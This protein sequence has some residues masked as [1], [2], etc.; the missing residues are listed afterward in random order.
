VSAEKTIESMRE[1]VSEFD[2]MKAT[3]ERQENDVRV[4]RHALK[5]LCRQREQK[6]TLGEIHAAMKD[7]RTVAVHGTGVDLIDISE[8]GGK[9]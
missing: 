8:E 9:A 1:I 3:I 4:Y 2:R 7:E 6:W 5:I